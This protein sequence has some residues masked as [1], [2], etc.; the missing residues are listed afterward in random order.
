M[1]TRSKDTEPEP[2][3]EEIDRRFHRLRRFVK[4]SLETRDKMAEEEQKALRDYA[5][6]L[7]TEIQ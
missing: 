7:V 1:H 2:Y 6:P 4:E 3:Y 5:M